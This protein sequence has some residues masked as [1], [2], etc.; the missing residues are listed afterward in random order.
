M[1]QQQVSEPLLQ[2]RG[3][4]IDVADENREK[5][6]VRLDELS[7]NKRQIVALVGE[8]GC[9]KT[10]TALS[11][12]GLL[13]A[14]VQV[15]AGEMWVAGTNLSACSSRQAERLRRRHLAMIFQDPVNA[16]N[17]VMSIGDQITEAI[18]CQRSGLSRRAAKNRALEQ[19]ER[20]G[21]RGAVALYK[22]YPFQISGGMCQRVMIAIALSMGADL[23]IADEPTTSLDVTVQAQIL[24]ELCKLRDETGLAILLITHDMGIVAEVADTVYVMRNGTI[25][26]SGE[27]FQI[28]DQASD[29]YTQALL[30][31]RRLA[32]TRG[33][34]GAG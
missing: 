21:L 23:L 30:P 24:K 4:R 14:P 1:G 16:L 3:L 6:I 17:P 10:L 15:H 2:I 27:V 26:E 29:P 9:G 18:R 13:D 31:P 19:M 5:A 28:F 25:V 33:G 32:G 22:K 8:S 12:L 7:V 34:R 20:V 11:I